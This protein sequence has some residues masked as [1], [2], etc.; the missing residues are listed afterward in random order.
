MSKKINKRK[1][2]AKIIDACR[3]SPFMSINAS[4]FDEK[5]KTEKDYKEAC[6]FCRIEPVFY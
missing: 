6:E 2:K 1:T 4:M 3:R 5:I